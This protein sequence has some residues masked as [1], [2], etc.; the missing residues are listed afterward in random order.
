MF[1]RSILASL[2]LGLTA[3]TAFAGPAGHHSAEATYHSG[4]AASHAT[5]AAATGAATVVA[6]P[7]VA[8][9]SA[10][11]VTG[12]ALEEAGTSTIDAGIQLSTPVKLK[13][14][15]EPCLLPCMRPGPAPTLD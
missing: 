3:T 12:A 5:A 8:V 7:V 10:L 6:V 13:P 9:G 4:E 2:A 15:G 11:A 14:A 1:M